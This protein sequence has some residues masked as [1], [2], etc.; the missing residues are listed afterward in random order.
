M[1]VFWGILRKTFSQTN[2]LKT[3]IAF[4]SQIPFLSEFINHYSFKGL[5]EMR[6]GSFF[7]HNF[8]LFLEDSVKKKCWLLCPGVDN[9]FLYSFPQSTIIEHLLNARHRL[10]SGQN[11]HGHC[12]V[13][14]T[15]CDNRDWH[16]SNIYLDKNIM[17][18]HGKTWKENYG[19]L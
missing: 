16:R 1:S 18:N 5:H 14:L 15:A 9:L 13:D 6:T 7:K 19:K 4:R 11:R 10:L 8:H 17:P 12:P 3:R 2:V